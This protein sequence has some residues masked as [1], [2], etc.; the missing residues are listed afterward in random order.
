MTELLQR[1]DK[2]ATN[3]T[4]FALALVLVLGS[5]V[6]LRL[7]T[8]GPVAPNL[9]L[10][11]VFYWTIY[12]PDLLPGVAVLLLGLWQDILVGAP[13]GLN[14]VTLLLVHGAIV[15][16]R[17]FFQGKSFPVIWW[18]FGLTAALAAGVFWLLTMGYHAAVVDPFPL[19]FQC[20]LTTAV[21]PFLTW[22]FARVHHAILR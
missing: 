20:A 22:L 11:A 1:L 21:F 9:A 2:V 4:P 10:I 14:A 12:R 17:T 13:L 8:F 18:A 6:P 7:P 19:L 3:L 16:Q 15:L 5:S